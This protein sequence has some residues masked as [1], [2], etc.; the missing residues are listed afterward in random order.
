VHSLG[1]RL[2]PVVGRLTGFANLRNHHRCR[3]PRLSISVTPRLLDGPPGTRELMRPT[4]PHGLSKSS[5]V[6]W[7]CRIHKNDGGRLGPRSIPPTPGQAGLSPEA[8]SHYPGHS[9]WPLFGAGLGPE[10][11]KC[12]FGTWSKCAKSCFWTWHTCAK[13][14]NQTWHIASVWKRRCAKSGFGT[15]HKCAKSKNQ[16]WAYARAQVCLI[17]SHF[18]SSAVPPAAFVPQASCFI[19]LPMPLL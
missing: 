5:G 16:T 10:A 4:P 8:S 19:L 1:K 9:P 13:S 18:G 12:A 17:R 7:C 11:A 3:H 15:W 14:L 6:S 2:L